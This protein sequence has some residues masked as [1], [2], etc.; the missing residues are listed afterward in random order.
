MIDGTSNYKVQNPLKTKKTKDVVSLLGVLHKKNGIVF[1]YPKAFKCD[2]GWEIKSEV[3]KLLE[4]HDVK[5]NRATEKY[6]LTHTAFFEAFNKE[7][8]GNI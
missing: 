7:L 6:K 8:T 5:L 3:T 2:N 4:Q 1:R